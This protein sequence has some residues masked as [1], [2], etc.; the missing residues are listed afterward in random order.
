MISRVVAAGSSR[1]KWIAARSRNPS[2]PGLIVV[3]SRPSPANGAPPFEEEGPAAIGGPAT[4]AD[5]TRQATDDDP[6]TTA[7]IVRGVSCSKCD[8]RGWGSAVRG[9]AGGSG[10]WMA[11]ALRRS[12]V[13]QTCNISLP[14]RACVPG[15]QD[16]L[17]PGVV[18]PRFFPA[19]QTVCVCQR[20]IG[21]PGVGPLIP[22]GIANIRPTSTSRRPGTFA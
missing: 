6:I 9:R 17:R 13:S 8:S 2:S 11:K 14:S 3:S 21:P 12:P 18:S 19:A 4:T 22:R 5:A 1:A 15:G 10:P 16:P 7:V 20:V